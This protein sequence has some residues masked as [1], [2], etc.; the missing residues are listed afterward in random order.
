VV[1]LDVD[2][3]G[4]VEMALMEQRF[5]NADSLRVADADNLGFH[6]QGSIQYDVDT[7]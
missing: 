1:S 2:F 4:A 6:G 3:H 7:K 5:R